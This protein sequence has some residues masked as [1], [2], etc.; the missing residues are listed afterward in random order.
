[1]SLPIHGIITIVTIALLSFASHDVFS[2]I[3]KSEQTTLSGDLSN[4][5][6]AQD[7]LKKIDQTTQWIADLE[8][9][10]YEKIEA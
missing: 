1:M 5:P 6:V 2:Q 7:I 3:E 10:E 4:N 9:R 8:Q